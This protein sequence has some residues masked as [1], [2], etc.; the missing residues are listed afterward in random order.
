MVIVSIIVLF[1]SFRLIP[2][3]FLLSWTRPGLK[4]KII[5]NEV[6]VN[7]KLLKPEVCRI[8]IRRAYLIQIYSIGFDEL[9]KQ[10]GYVNVF[11]VQF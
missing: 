9:I 8:P 10:N 6:L 5:G 1:L 3:F 11:I 2:N 7:T 4:V